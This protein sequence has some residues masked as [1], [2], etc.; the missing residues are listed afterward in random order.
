MNS[1]PAQARAAL[2]GWLGPG[3]L[4]VVVLALFFRFYDP[5]REVGPAVVPGGDFERP[6]VESGWKATKTVQWAPGSG[7]NGSGAARIPADDGKG[8][9][10]DFVIEDPGRFE[11]FRIDAWIKTDAVRVGQY[12]WCN[13]RVLLYYKDADNKSITN[14]PH[15]ACQMLAT[16]DWT[17]CRREFPVPPGASRAIAA[18]QNIGSAGTA[19]FDDVTVVP[20]ARRAAAP[21]LTWAAV[22]LWAGAFLWSVIALKLWRMRFGLLT[23]V[24]MLGIIAGVSLPGALLDKTALS[25][26][27]VLQAAIT[28]AESTP[29]A[30]AAKPGPTAPSPP[31]AGSRATG[32]SKPVPD[33]KAKPAAPS[34]AEAEA[35]RAKAIWRS[36]M[37]ES[38]HHSGHIV[39]FAVLGLVLGAGLVG[40]SP[41]WAR[42]V[43]GA[44]VGGLLFAAATEVL[45]FAVAYRQPRWSDV[46]RDA[47][48]LAAGL[49]VAQLAVALWTRLRR[50]SEPR[51]RA[52]QPSAG[53]G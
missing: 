28:R 48:G 53:T 12:R 21:Y 3:L 23:L 40:A 45:Q 36:R 27:E 25:S 20:V 2:R 30:A 41:E 7:R 50:K 6:P 52:P 33:A 42:R 9:T 17:Q 34:P 5:Y 51:Q 32:P 26:V 29:P 18:L 39:M 19:W 10:L 14:I 46:G 1:F 8:G 22:V 31:P 15:A 13:A 43:L 37:T 47:L 49:L 35:A 44:L 11:Q 38:L 16:N 24:V 4:V